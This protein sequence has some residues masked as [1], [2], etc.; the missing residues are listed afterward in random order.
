MANTRKRE[1]VAT[2]SE[3]EKNRSALDRIKNPAKANRFTASVIDVVI[4]LVVV[5]LFVLIGIS[6]FNQIPAYVAV[7]TEHNNF[8]TSSQLYQLIYDGSVRPI[9]FSEYFDVSI[10]VSPESESPE[11]DSVMPRQ[12]EAQYSDY[13]IIQVVAYY[14]LSYLSNQNLRQFSAEHP[15]Y[16][17][18]QHYEELEVGG[19]TGEP[20]HYDMDWFNQNILGLPE[21]G[22]INES[23]HFVYRTLADGI[24]PDYTKTGIPKPDYYID[25]SNDPAPNNGEEIDQNKADYIFKVAALDLLIPYMQARFEAAFLNLQQHTYFI[26]V[27][28][29]IADT[30]HYAM[31]GVI[32]LTLVVFNLIIPLCKKNGQTIGRLLFKIAVVNQRSG[33][34]VKKWQTLLRFAVPLLIIILG[35]SLRI[36]HIL[37]VIGLGV[38]L[39]DISLVLFHP[40]HLS[41]PD[42]LSFTALS[43]YK[44]APIFKDKEEE[45]QF[46]LGEKRAALIAEAQKKKGA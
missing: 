6:F 7:Q 10:P 17:S 38:F 26:R 41:V 2:L 14:Y 15:F 31:W 35:F 44:D 19:L 8:L 22:K 21:A 36:D 24:T 5:L 30:T 29:I 28:T 42:L 20:T 34:R 4:P 25:H 43:D 27:E 45:N 39:I 18:S 12:T 32:S 46:F 1:L 13:N 11:Y 16:Y 33:F 23:P 40:K 9:E 3:E 37:L